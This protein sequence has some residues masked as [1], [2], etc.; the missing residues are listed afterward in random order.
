MGET[1]RN[2]QE[3]AQP[4]NLLEMIPTGIFAHRR[5]VICMTNNKAMA[6]LGLIPGSVLGRNLLELVHPEDRP[7]VVGYQKSL[8]AKE[9]SPLAS[10]EFR[11]QGSGGQCRWLQLVRRPLP[12]AG[13]FMAAVLDVTED[14]MRRDA[15]LE[16]DR[17][18][19]SLFESI[20][21]GQSVL[22]T[23]MN[24]LHLNPTMERWYSH[25]VALQGKKCYQ[26]YHGRTEPCV[27]CPV[28][29]TLETGEPQK[30]MVPLTGPDGAAR[31]WLELHSVPF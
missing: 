22:D 7:T 2:L 28:K 31:G 8:A 4:G 20:P 19:E 12:E 26:T 17:F 23:Q 15:L 9:E 21:Q 5:G 29:R 13:S 18:L 1:G 10:C 3:I 30:E 11:V 27:K 24:I 25:A 14:K 6:L 16:S